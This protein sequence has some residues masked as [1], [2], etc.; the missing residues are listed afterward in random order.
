LG[1]LGFDAAAYEDERQRMQQIVKTLQ[2]NG[3]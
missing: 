1:V 2:S 3:I